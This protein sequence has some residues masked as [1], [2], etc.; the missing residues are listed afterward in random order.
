MVLIGELALLVSS[1]FASAALY[2]NVVEQ[3]ARMGL[4]DRA[5]LA[6]WKT[7]YAGSTSAA[8]FWAG[9]L[10][11]VSRR[12]ITFPGWRV[13]HDCKLALDAGGDDA[14]E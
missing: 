6:E 11:V 5:L 9:C 2:I 3:P 4:D 13:I 1:L 8:W 12:A 14:S 7:A 10:G